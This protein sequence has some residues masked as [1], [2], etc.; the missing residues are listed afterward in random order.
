MITQT[1]ANIKYDRVA[2][3]FTSEKY[4][5]ALR[6]VALQK[7]KRGAQIHQGVME[8]LAGYQRFTYQTLNGMATIRTNHVKKTVELST[9]VDEGF[10]NELKKVLEIN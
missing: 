3:M 5:E 8:F 9:L 2:E 6:L 7:T 4:D 10:A 1:D